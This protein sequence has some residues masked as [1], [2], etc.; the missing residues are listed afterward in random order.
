MALQLANATVFRFDGSDLMPTK[1]NDAFWRA[2]LEYVNTP[3]R[4]DKILQ[5]IEE[6]ATEAYGK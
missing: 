2:T 4:L 1:V 3:T 5:A 6:V